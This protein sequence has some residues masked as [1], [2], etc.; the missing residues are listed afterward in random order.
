MQKE[1][2][3]YYVY[4]H[5]RESDDTVFY[6]GKGRKNRIYSQHGRNRLWKEITKHGWYYVK[7]REN[8]NENQA[9]DLE[10]EMINKLLPEAN[11]HR[12]D[13]RKKSIDLDFINKRYAYSDKSPSGLVY[14]EY[15]NQFGKKARNIGDVAGTKNGGGYYTV[16]CKGSGNLL[17]HR[18]IW[19]IVN[20]E[21][22][23]NFVIDH[24][25]GDRQNN[26][27]ENLR[28]IDPVLNA[29]NLTKR[30]DNSTGLAGVTLGD[31]RYVVSWYEN[32]VSFSKAF[33]ILKYGEDLAK[34]LAFYYRLNLVPLEGFSDRHIG[35]F[36]F[37]LL[38]NKSK[39]EINRMVEDNLRSSNRSGFSGIHEHFVGEH[40]FWVFRNKTHSRMFS[41]TKFGNYTANLLAIEYKSRF[42]GSAPSNIEGYSIVET[43]SMLEDTS[44]ARSLSGFRGISYN[45]SKRN[46]TKIIATKYKNKKNYR[47]V[48]D[49]SEYGLLPA[50]AKAMEWLDSFRDKE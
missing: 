11:I 22:P 15:N 1:K 44:T 23:L 37:K 50:F 41:S 35:S 20:G 36:E 21:D 28:K 12:K 18:V 39:E 48:F 49:C 38:T 7:F 47:V 17:A 16:S 34:E 40:H 26:K 30:K 3:D 8:L 13:I 5:V 46:V 10:L 42:S 24:I 27:I 45:V 4:F 2:Q 29:R 19:A 6:I 25:D 31:N 14:R 33:S 9:L 32:G 43:N